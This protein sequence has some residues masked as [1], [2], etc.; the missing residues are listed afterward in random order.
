M[1]P[2]RAR[3]PR[4][5]VYNPEIV[6]VRHLGHCK[7][8]SCPA[9]SVA[10]MKQPKMEPAIIYTHCVFQDRDQAACRSESAS[11]KEP[12]TSRALQ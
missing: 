5:A 11:G 6:Q 10:Y 4:G 9:P 1:D 12:L 7:T 8:S 2:Q 3:K